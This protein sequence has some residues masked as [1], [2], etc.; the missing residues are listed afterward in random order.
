MVFHML[1]C[2]FS[3]TVIRQK[4][5]PPTPHP[6]HKS[7]TKQWASDLSYGISETVESCC[8]S[9]HPFQKAHF[10][11]GLCSQTCFPFSS[12][13]LTLLLSKIASAST[14]SIRKVYYRNL[15]SYLKPRGTFSHS[16]CLLTASK[17]KKKKED[18][19]FRRGSSPF[20][21]LT[22]GMNR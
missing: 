10:P 14:F 11:E 5:S 22:W 13:H 21:P 19:S 1:E 18:F 15:E 12:L 17:K 16:L 9:S 2:F 6:V 8:R 3:P 20:S 7:T 4:A